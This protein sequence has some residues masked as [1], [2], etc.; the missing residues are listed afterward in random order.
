MTRNAVLA[1]VSH[2]PIYAPLSLN[3]TTPTSGGKCCIETQKYN[4]ENVSSETYK[5]M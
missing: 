1:Q 4:P 5:W 2:I 3:T